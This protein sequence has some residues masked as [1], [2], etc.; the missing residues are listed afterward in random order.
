MA[1][2]LCFMLNKIYIDRHNYIILNMN[3]KID[4]TI[5]VKSIFNDQL[6]ISRAY[7]LSTIFIQV[8]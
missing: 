8:K 5:T 3:K 1:A 2:G 6:I 4:G 7:P